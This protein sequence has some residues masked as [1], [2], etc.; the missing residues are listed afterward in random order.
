MR[1]VPGRNGSSGGNDGC[2]K[3]GHKRYWRQCTGVL[4]RPLFWLRCSM[5]ARRQ[6]CPSGQRGSMPASNWKRPLRDRKKGCGILNGRRYP[7]WSVALR[8]QKGVPPHPSP[9]E[10]DICVIFKRQHPVRQMR[11][12]DLSR[13][14]RQE[15]R[16]PNPAILS[17]SFQHARRFWSVQSCGTLNLPVTPCSLALVAPWGT[18]L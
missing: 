15:R 11:S 13:N 4:A 7:L 3:I 9:P 1:L 2:L 18:G 10:A 8:F 6:R 16:H 14:F 17:I 12:R 5:G